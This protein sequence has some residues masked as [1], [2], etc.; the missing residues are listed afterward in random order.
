MEKNIKRII[1]I[2]LSFFIIIILNSCPPAD[3]SDPPQPTDIYGITPTPKPG[4]YQL[5]FSTEGSGVIEISA[6][7]WTETGESGSVVII[8]KS[9]ATFNAKAND[10]Y[11]FAYWEGGVNSDDNP[12]SLTMDSDKTIKAFFSPICFQY[13]I[14]CDCSGR[15]FV[16]Y[17]PDIGFYDHT[18]EEILCSCEGSCLDTYLTI[19]GDLYTV[20]LIPVNGAPTF[21]YF[22]ETYTNTGYSWK[23]FFGE[24]KEL[25]HATMTP[26]V[27]E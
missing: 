7:G 2:T 4:T 23:T 9:I 12:T 3:N 27:C 8:A 25:M 5:H 20:S 14:V 19:G 10:G 17:N 18:S 1:S 15:H 6:D 24:P 11:E 22:D 16:K 26:I 21:F 13:D